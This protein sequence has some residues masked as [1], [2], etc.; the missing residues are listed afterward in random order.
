MKPVI[1][2]LTTPKA[3]FYFLTC[4]ADKVYIE[5]DQAARSSNVT[6]SVVEVDEAN[7]W[8]IVLMES[9]RTRNGVGETARVTI[10]LQK[11]PRFWFPVK[12]GDTIEYELAESA[13]QT[14]ARSARFVAFADRSFDEVDDF[15]STTLESFSTPVVDQVLDEV[16]RG[17]ESPFFKI[18]RL[19]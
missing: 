15:F 7:D 13:G 4:R 12:I 6:G 14:T 8:C 3:L 17:K 11:L 5:N 2:N 1:T 9:A 10:H 19:T 16:L 18:E